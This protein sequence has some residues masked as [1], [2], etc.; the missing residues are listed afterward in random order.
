MLFYKYQG[1]G[2]DFVMIDDRSQTFPI[3]QELISKLCH[4]RFGI[5]ADGLILLQNDPDYDFRM[6][7][8][9][10]D[11]NESSMCGNGGRC[12]VKFAYNLGVFTD[13]ATFIA[14][15]GEHEAFLKDGLVHLKMKDVDNIEITDTYNFLN[16]GSPHYVEFVEDLEAYPVFEK[17]KQIRYN[18]IFGPKGGTNV[19]FLEKAE[20]QTLF[21]RTYER[22]VEDETYSCGTGVTAA[23]LSASL[24]GWISPVKIKTLGG[25]LQVSFQKNADT[26]FTDIY[27]IGPAE[28]V[29]SG[30][31]S[32]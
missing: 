28:E 21:V 8:F 20:T 12:L 27:L 29:F 16:T 26:S 19:N 3:N 9:N 4:R 2:N 7:Y 17:G 32:L 14:V 23:A 6:V 11:G 1:T 10:A 31:I 5:G 24:Q 25:N 18:E 22:G 13:R 30:N 15:D